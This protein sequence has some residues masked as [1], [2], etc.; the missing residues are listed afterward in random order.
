[1]SRPIL[2]FRFW[3]VTAQPTNHTNQAKGGPG[4]RDQG[5]GTKNLKFQT[6]NFKSPVPDLYLFRVC[7]VFRG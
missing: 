1:M 7:S 6:S 5:S 2:D 4:I 3:I